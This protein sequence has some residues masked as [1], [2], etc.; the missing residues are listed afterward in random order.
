MK[1]LFKVRVRVKRPIII[2]KFTSVLCCFFHVGLVIFSHGATIIFMW[3]CCSSHV[4]LMFFSC[5]CFSCIGVVIFFAW[6]YYSSCLV[7]LLFSHWWC[8]SSRVGV[9][10]LLV[11]CYYSSTFYLSPLLLLF[12]CCVVL[13]P[14]V[15]VW[16]F[17]PFYLMEVEAWNTRL[18]NCWFCW[19]K[20]IHFIFFIYFW[21]IMV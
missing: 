12:F 1:T 13:S 19:W 10:I 14:L 2:K 8:C 3:S 15:L 17:L 7:M 9:I 6:S 18:V 16:Y 5:W 20:K 4:I 11:W 21:F